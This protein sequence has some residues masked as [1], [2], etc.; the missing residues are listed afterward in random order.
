MRQSPAWLLFVPVLLLCSCGPAGP[1]RKETYPVTG[2][3]VV[4]GNE[5]SG[6]TVTLHDT[7]GMDAE[8]PTFSQATTDETGKFSLSTYEGG[9]GVPEGDYL[10]TFTWGEFNALSRSMEGDKLKGKYG[11][12]KKSE[13]KLNVKAGS[14]IDMGRIE[15]STQ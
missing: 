7:K 12:A 3:V 14:P 9:D 8:M 13:F 4:D 5:A 15:L 6:V 11:D 10:V 1:A 2:V